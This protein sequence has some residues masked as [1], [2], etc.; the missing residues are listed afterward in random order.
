MNRVVLTV[1][2]TAPLF[3]VGGLFVYAKGAAHQA[4]EKREAALAAATHA[5]TMAAAAAQPAGDAKPAAGVQMV[6]PESL[7]QGFILVVKDLTGL[8]NANSPIHLASSHNGWDP[9]DPKQKLEARSDLRWQIVLPKPKTDAPLA[10]KFTRGNWDLEELNPELQAIANRELPM[11]D[12]SKLAPGEKPIFEFEI[13][14]WGDQRPSAAA[15]P[16]LDPYFVLKSDA[17]IKRLQVAGGGVPMTRDVFVLLPEGYDDPANAARTYPVLYLQD[18]QNLFMKM[19][20]IPAEWGVDETAAALIKAGTIEPVI[21]VG[22]P[23]AMKDR[24][25]EYLP[26]AALDG[27]E[28]RGAQ[29]IE[30]VTNEVMPRVERAF[31]VKTGPANTAIGGSSLG[32][33][34]ALEAATTRPDK[35][36]AVLLESMSLL[37][38][39]QR[40]IDHFKAAKAWPKKVYFAMGKQEAGTD[41]KNAEINA[42]YV[43]GAEAFGKLIQAQSGVEAFIRI[44]DGVHSE[45]TWAKRLPDALSFLYGKK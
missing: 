22:I 21:I 9:G 3:I 11:V 32:A 28:P 20:S 29:Y 26:I 27:V 5:A 19:P 42:K 43:A 24:A 39:K 44:E 38:E 34:I 17:N 1:I 10:F 33:L 8:A 18:G 2:L 16:D 7:P 25:A 36:G 41:P 30:F 35:F 13:P 15:R 40:A 23:H 12:A 45:E 14:K 37:G 4:R 6:R 31:R